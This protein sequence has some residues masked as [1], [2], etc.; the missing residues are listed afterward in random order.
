MYYLF[1][2][3]ICILLYKQTYTHVIYNLI[4]TYLAYTN[5]FKYLVSNLFNLLSHTVE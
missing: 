3:I 1:S 5:K 4:C 2:A